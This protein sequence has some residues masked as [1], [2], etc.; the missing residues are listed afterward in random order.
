MSSLMTVATLVLLLGAPSA[1]R[2]SYRGLLP[3]G[4]SRGRVEYRG[5]SFDVRAG[6]SIP[7]WG[8]VRA[9]T[10]GYLVV[11]RTLSDAEKQARAAAGL[12]V[13]DVQDVRIPKGA[14]TLDA[15]TPA[16]PER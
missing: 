9:V 4:T 15:A 2:P 11:R 6:D 8:T 5:K 13:V 16:P 10:E 7:G 1:Q 14:R 12:L 3:D